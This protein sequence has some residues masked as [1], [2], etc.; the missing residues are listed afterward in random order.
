ME[1]GSIPEGTGSY[2]TVQHFEESI[3]QRFV[4][5]FCSSV[6]KSCLTLLVTP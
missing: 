2:K 1:C 6:A 5:D 4:V 3:T